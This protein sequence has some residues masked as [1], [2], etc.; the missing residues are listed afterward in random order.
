MKLI[1]RSPTELVIR[2][3]PNVFK[4]CFI[5]LWSS[6]F[7]GIP[8]ALLVASIANVGV[9]RLHCVQVE[10]SQLSC[11]VAR[12]KFLGAVS[13]KPVSYTQV[14]AAKFNQT[15][16]T[17]RDGDDTQDNWASLVTSQGEITLFEDPIR[18][19]GT[20]GSETE[21]QD[22][23]DEVNTYIQSGVTTFKV[24]RDLSLSVTQLLLPALFCSVFIVVGFGVLYWT[25]QI[26]WARFDRTC[27][28]VDWKRYSLLGV[29]TVTIAFSEIQ[30]VAIDQQTDS[31]GP[32][33][34]TLY[35]DMADHDRM[36]LGTTPWS[37]QAHALKTQIQQFLNPS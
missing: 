11:A 26:R 25:L 10:L 7:V 28:R 14:K 18:Y 27:D 4:S 34:Y 29:K 12:S 2:D 23:S 9:T 36:T 8:S 16:G 20:R 33:S 6:F 5:L 13:G 22:L 21:M 32:S 35:L 24:E 37:K 31:D 15:E 19:N 30:A 17:D 3:R 1:K